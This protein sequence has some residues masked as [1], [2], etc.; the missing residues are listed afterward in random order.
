MKIVLINGK[1][2]AGK[3]VVGYALHRKLIKSAFIEGDAFLQINPFNP[4]KEQYLLVAKN[5]VQQI[6][7]Y[8][9]FKNITY[10]VLSWIIRDK[11]V[12]DLIKNSLNK[13]DLYPICLENPDDI[14][15]TRVEKQIKNGNKFD[16]FLS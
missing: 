14:L 4:S 15:K 2:G 1:I 9:K 7:T 8:A 13:F 16:S 11:E 5:I 6:K 12:F 3:S 10:V